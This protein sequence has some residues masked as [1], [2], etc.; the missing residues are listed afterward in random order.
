MHLRQLFR[1]NLLIVTYN[2]N[3][4]SD[5][6][7]KSIVVCIGLLIVFIHIS[8]SLTGFNKV[9][10]KLIN[11]DIKICHLSVCGL[12]IGEVLNKILQNLWDAICQKSMLTI[13]LRKNKQTTFS[14]K[15]PN[16]ISNMNMTLRNHC[17]R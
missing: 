11:K 16:F 15:K 12:R 13:L 7:K 17:V 2:E 4:K 10:N 14:L 5:S 8:V 1:K 9:K 6:L 3:N